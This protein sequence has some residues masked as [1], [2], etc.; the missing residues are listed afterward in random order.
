MLYFCGYYDGL[1]NTSAFIPSKFDSIEKV[2]LFVKAHLD[3]FRTKCYG[4]TVFT[5]E[6]V[7]EGRHMVP[8]KLRVWHRDGTDCTG[9]LI[10]QNLGWRIYIDAAGNIAEEHFKPKGD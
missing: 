8:K 4:F 7:R 3:Y 1:T 9:E 2:M 10:N 6:E 5:D